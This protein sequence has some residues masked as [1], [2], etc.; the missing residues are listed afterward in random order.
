M[1][2]LVKLKDHLGI[3]FIKT[4]TNFMQHCLSKDT[5]EEIIMNQFYMMEDTIYKQNIY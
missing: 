2:P 1:L 5:L 3:T 4:E